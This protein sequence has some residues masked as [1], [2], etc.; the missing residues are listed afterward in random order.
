MKKLITV[1]AL[2]AF[3]LVG[4]N[5]QKTP[6]VATVDVQRVLNDYNA[7]QAAVEK[8][9]GSVEPVEDEMRKMQENIQSII[10]KGRDAE[11]LR[12]NPASS[13]EAKAEASA[14]VLALQGQLREEQIK[15]QQFQ[16]QARQL[17]Q[18]GQQDELAPLQEKAVDAVKIVAEDKGIDL[19]I[20]KNGVIFSS[21]ELEITDAVIALLNSEAG[22]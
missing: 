21:D 14:E 12:E 13:E 19:V 17:A 5:A 22:Q 2:S 15:L 20:P 6:V 4:L 3:A 11:L 10:A 1:I 16:Q 8:V 18:Q 9:R 7:F